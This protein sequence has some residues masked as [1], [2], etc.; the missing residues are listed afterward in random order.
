MVDAAVT[1]PDAPA[2]DAWEELV[3]QAGGFGVRLSPPQ[4]DALRR[5]LDLLRE[6][7]QRFNLTAIQSPGEILI[8]HFLDSLSCRVL[9]PFEEQERL[10]DVGTGAGFPGLVLKIAYPHLEVTLL[11]AVRKRLNFLDRVIE[12]LRLERVKT[13]HA[14]AED[15]AR[16]P[17]PASR[18]GVRTGPPPGPPD[19]LREAYDVVTAR[20]VARLDV[21]AEWMLPFA[22]VGGTALAMKGPHASEELA[23]ARRAMQHLGAGTP[24]VREFVLPGTDVGRSLIL[25]PKVR[26]T[27]KTYPRPP[28]TARK[29]PL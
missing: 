17:V 13:V 23:E 12:D 24:T 16:P 4:I 29:H 26:S 7:N 22:R 11:D 19:S 27:P 28:G 1:L 2:G 8:K 10:I 9:V 3:H 14:R 5:Y 20:A 15:A 6:W 21:L 25:M 18:T